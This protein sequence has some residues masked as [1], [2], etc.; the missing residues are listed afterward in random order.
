MRAQNPI[1][2][3][4]RTSHPSPL[5]SLYH[6]SLTLVGCADLFSL[7]FIRSP[8]LLTRK[9]RIRIQSV[10]NHDTVFWHSF[11]LHSLHCDM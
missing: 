8:S 2:L 10:A 4:L 7:F 5:F 6:M 11:N 1:T 3:T 9:I